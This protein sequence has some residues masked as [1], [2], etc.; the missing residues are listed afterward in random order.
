[1]TNI[2]KM[3]LKGKKETKVVD[4]NGYTTSINIQDDWIYY[5]DQDDK[6][7]VQ[8]FRIKTNGSNKQSL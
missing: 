2:C 5:P 3:D 7:N 8:M 1:M 4:I 6:G